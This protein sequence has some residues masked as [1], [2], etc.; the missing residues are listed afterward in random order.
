MAA[1]DLDTPKTWRQLL[2]S[3]NKQRWPK[4]VDDE[5]ASLLGMNTWRLVPRPQKRKI[6]K[7]KVFKIKRRPDRS[8]Q[9]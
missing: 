6:I 1:E 2:K 5:F 3:P 8:R 7:S 4:A 9:D